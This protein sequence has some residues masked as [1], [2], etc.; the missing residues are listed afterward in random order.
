MLAPTSLDLNDLVTDLHKMLGRLIGEDINLVMVLQPGLWSVKAD[1]G[2]IEQ[3]IVN[4]AANARD[5]MPTGGRLTIETRNVHLDDSYLK[6]HPES[7]T[8]SCVMLAV[9][10]TGHGMDAPTQAHIFEPFFTTKEV[11][12]GT[13]LGLATVY[14]I[15][16]QSGGDIIVYS[17][18]GHSTTFK[19][20]LP[21]SETVPDLAIPQTP[22][23]SHAG[24]ETILL[25]E[26]EDVVRNLV[27]RTLQG[28]GY[29]VLE[30]RHG[31]EA[32]SLASQL[33]DQLI[34]S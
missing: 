21:A 29:T 24:T 7:P 15:I 28:E 6:T 1:P 12:Q 5:A 13:G 17:E 34:Y 25:V 33:Q 4:L 20:Y 3:V 11:G 10:D 27:G 2:Q 23:A 31:G 9:T 18:P 32:L 8:G 22:P 14:G 16:K 26:D 30:A 19:I